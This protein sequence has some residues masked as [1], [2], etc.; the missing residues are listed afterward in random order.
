MSEFNLKI[1]I[2]FRACQDKNI[3]L[4]SSFL[5]CFFPL[6]SQKLK[7]SVPPYNDNHY[8]SNN[9]P[10][11][12]PHHYETPS[13]S[14]DQY[15]MRNMSTTSPPPYPVYHQTNYSND[16]LGP[17]PNRFSDQSRQ[18][19]PYMNRYDS[20]DEIEKIIPRER[21]KRS[22]I[23]KM[24]CGCCTCCPKWLRWCTC[25]IFII[26]VILAIV[27]G[28]LV[29]IFKVPDVQFTGLT[30]DPQFTYANNILSIQFDVG[31]SVDNQNFE[32]IT[33]ETIKAEVSENS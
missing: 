4:F 33:F 2:T 14:P 16:G 23:D 31:I 7:M 15:A 26:I 18:S 27:I 22:C 9:T 5:L 32:S 24:C 11:P 13:N 8:Y 3:N 29:G 25:I 10:P 20:D 28:V 17:G 6:Y 19:T 30:Q 1:R 12:L 21:K